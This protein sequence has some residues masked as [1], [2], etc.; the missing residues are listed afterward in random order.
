M[1]DSVKKKNTYYILVAAAVIIAAVILFG[2]YLRDRNQS[3]VKTLT[4]NFLE[5]SPKEAKYQEVLLLNSWDEEDMKEIERLKI[6]PKHYPSGVYFKKLDKEGTFD[7]DAGI[8]VSIFDVLQNYTD[9]ADRKYVFNSWEDFVNASKKDDNLL[10][11][12]YFIIK[13]KDNKIISAE[14]KLY[15]G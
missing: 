1:K 10:K 15:L 8:K 6:E 11:N 13:V 7:I 12:R 4:V 5:V 3:D 9:N 14:E 2:K